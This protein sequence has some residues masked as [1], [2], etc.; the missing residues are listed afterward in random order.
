M[1][2]GKCA[3]IRQL[4]LR[5]RSPVARFVPD[6]LQH[7][8]QCASGLVSCDTFESDLRMHQQGL[9]LTENDVRSKVMACRREPQR[10]GLQQ[11][12][13]WLSVLAAKPAAP[14]INYQTVNTWN[15]QRILQQAPK[16]PTRPVGG[17]DVGGRG[18]RSCS[19]KLMHN[20]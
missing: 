3:Q 19:C 5:G 11:D 15:A 8:K 6:Y 4:R 14:T 1:S 20:L 12:I 7:C 16:V 9:G 17:R 10:V 18:I 13:Q 2:C